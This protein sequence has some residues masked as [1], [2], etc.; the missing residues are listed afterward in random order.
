[1]RYDVLHPCKPTVLRELAK[2]LDDPKRSVRKEAVEAR[3]V[4]Q[5]VFLCLLTLFY[6]NDLVKISIRHGIKDVLIYLRFKY[7]G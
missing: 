6:K 1:M 3:Y 4:T 7:K 2:V 5:L